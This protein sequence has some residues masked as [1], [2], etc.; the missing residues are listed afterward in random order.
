MIFYHQA[1]WLKGT[2]DTF[3]PTVGE[4]ALLMK[5]APDSSRNKLYTPC[6]DK[7]VAEF[8]VDNF[9]AIFKWYKSFHN[10]QQ[11]RCTCK[12]F[13]SVLQQEDVLQLNYKVCQEN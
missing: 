2:K 8:H 11:V 7:Q 13:L 5:T 4:Q 3:S 12:P 9:A 1:V 6:F 10:E